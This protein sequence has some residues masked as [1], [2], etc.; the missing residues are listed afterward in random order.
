MVKL[1]T[2]YRFQFLIKSVS[3]GAVAQVLARARR[4]AELRQWPATA[5]IVDVD[6][7]EFL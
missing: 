1:R 7:V 6:P 2:E 3:R 5:L 4:F